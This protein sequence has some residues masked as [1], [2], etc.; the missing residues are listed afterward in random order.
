MKSVD[1][2]AIATLDATKP[3]PSKVGLARPLTAVADKVFTVLI[4]ED[5]PAELMRTELLVKKFGY[6]TL[7][8][9]DGLEA[10]A[11]LNHH[12]VDL[13]LSDW[14]MPNMD[15]MALCQAVRKKI[16]DYPYFVL[17]T[18]RSNRCELVAA[19][20]AGAD[21]Y[22]SKPVKA[23]ELRV[24][25]RAGIRVR[26]LSDNLAQKNKT[27]NHALKRERQLNNEI[28]ASLSAAAKLQVSTLP[29]QSEVANQVAI[30]HC[31]RPAQGVAGDSYSLL[32]LDD[33]HVI[34][35]HIDVAGHGIRA[36]MH[37]YAVV[38]SL[39]ERV[40]QYA[41][42]PAQSP[43]LSPV[44]VAKLLNAE[45]ACTGDCENYFTLVYGV[46]SIAT[47]QAKL[48]RAGHPHPYLVNAC[49]EIKK[50]GV[51]GF[52]IG[53]FPHA[54]YEETCFTLASGS[55]L[56]VYS[57][58]IFECTAPSG[59]K[60]NE[61]MLL[62]ILA[63]IRSTKIL[64]LQSHLETIVDRLIGSNPILDDLSLFVLEPLAAAEHAA[65]AAQQSALPCS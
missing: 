2:Y 17:L 53:L 61:A 28:E 65:S 40:R 15:G 19:M 10:I 29:A 27:L 3:E 56:V 18:A 52:P 14:Q 45:F 55:K 13:I 41:L 4:V 30:A 1:D 8:A 16:N 59:V 64:T 49:G 32:K 54:Q 34:F 42:N 24:R 26:A 62:Q 51:G 7:S 20:D 33:E 21:D 25:I 58:G 5:S 57:D 47:G 12:K 31:F 43:L 9:K 44:S 50:L 6:H 11:K 63:S 35:Y 46:L 39:Q 23:E 38:R 36:A 60:F 37:S 22:L 48:I